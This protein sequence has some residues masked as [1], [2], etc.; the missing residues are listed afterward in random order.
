[1][2]EAGDRDSFLL[3]D[4]EFH[5]LILKSSGNEMFS[6]LDSLVEQVLTGRTHYGLMPTHPH[7]EALQLHINVA[8][9]IQ[10]GSPDTAHR[11]MLSIMH[12]TLQEMSE[13]WQAGN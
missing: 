8:K 3:L 11:T 13:F 5:R 2:G 6:K 9:A 4:V 1:L 12:R 7:E 10:R